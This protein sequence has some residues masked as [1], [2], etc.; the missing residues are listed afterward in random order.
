[1]LPKGHIDMLKAVCNENTQHGTL[2]DSYS[3]EQKSL[4]SGS[5]GIVALLHGP[6]GVGKT[7][8]VGP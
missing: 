1:M 6:P 7:L 3:R 4:E 8:T 5:K 2:T